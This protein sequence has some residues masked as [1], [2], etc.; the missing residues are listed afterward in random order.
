MNSLR[1]DLGITNSFAQAPKLDELGL[2][3]E[4]SID[5]EYDQKKLLQI[6]S[7]EYEFWQRRSKDARTYAIMISISNM[8]FQLSAILKPSNPTHQ[9][10]NLIY[11]ANSVL[12]CGLI[13]Q[14]YYTECKL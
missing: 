7:Q 11:S 13:I 8:Y 1:M 14:S 4:T 6:E 12:I 9:A 3:D 5:H 2:S 10:I